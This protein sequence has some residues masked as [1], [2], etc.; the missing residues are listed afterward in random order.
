MKEIKFI[1]WD[2][3]ENNMLYNN[4]D[5][6]IKVLIE[7]FKKHKL[8]EFIG[9]PKYYSSR[10]EF[11]QYIYRKDE[12]GKEIYEG[13]IIAGVDENFIVF[14]DKKLSSYRLKSTIREKYC[15]LYHDIHSLKVIGN[16]FQNPELLK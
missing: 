14:F 10:F 2:K 8:C 5:F 3:K 4:R 1:V 11:L 12:T 15:D 9:Y 16:K 6:L 7:N 13:D